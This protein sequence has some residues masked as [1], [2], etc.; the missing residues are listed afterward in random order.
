MP[1]LGCTRCLPQP[2]A[3]P[4]PV[5]SSQ[6][7]EFL[8]FRLQGFSHGLCASFPQH[9]VGRM[10]M[11]TVTPVFLRNVILQRAAPQDMP[12]H[13]QDV[14]TSTEACSIRQSSR[15]QSA[16]SHDYLHNV[17]AVPRFGLHQ[18]PHRGSINSPM[19]HASVKH[20]RWKC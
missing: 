10:L 11:L 19:L 17:A 20:E 3:A 15:K 2:L 18:D 1:L 5:S 9:W 4:R 16:A 8:G 6:S 13:R 7:Y 12:V 14:R